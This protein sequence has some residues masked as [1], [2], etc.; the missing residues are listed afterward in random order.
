MVTAKRTQLLL[1]SIYMA[2]VGGSGRLRG[3]RRRVTQSLGQLD[4]RDGEEAQTPTGCTDEAQLLLYGPSCQAPECRAR[5]WIGSPH[6]PAA[7]RS[8]DLRNNVG[9][10]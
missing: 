7:L 5:C 2:G 10:P 3:G 9:R 4:R 1:A 6:L 8:H